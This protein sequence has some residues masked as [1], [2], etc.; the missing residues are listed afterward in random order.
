MRPIWSFA[1]LPLALLPLRAVENSNGY[2]ELDHAADPIA[3][4]VA[5][6]DTGWGSA[7]AGTTGWDYVG[8][9][10]VPDG[11][12]SGVYLGNGYVLTAAHGGTALDSFTLDGVS[13]TPDPS[14]EKTFT[15]YGDGTGGQADLLTFKLTTTPP[16]ITLPPLSLATS[17]PVGY[18]A[19]TGAAGSDTVMVGFGFPATYPGVESWGTGN[20]FDSPI[21]FNIEQF[22]S[23]DYDIYDFQSGQPQSANNDY[24]LYPGDSGGA[25]FIYNAASKQWQLAGINEFV[26]T[27][28]DPTTGQTVP[29]GSGFVQVDEYLDQIDT[30]TT[31][32]PSTVALLVGGLAALAFWRRRAST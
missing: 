26:G 19:A 12:L 24:N 20:V 7:P 5:N 22:S 18:N 8:L 32:E 27:Y 25:D 2:F 3:G 21:L 11:Y 30:Y 17:L 6:W 29:I 28:T 15:T 10:T 14:T 1:L 16:A 31:P 13:Y 4:Q 9:I 23:V